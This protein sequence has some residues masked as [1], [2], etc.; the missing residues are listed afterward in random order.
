V[1]PKEPSCSVRFGDVTKIPENF[2][3]ASLTS[4]GFVQRSNL[5]ICLG[6]SRTFEFEPHQAMT[7]EA[8]LAAN[9]IRKWVHQVIVTALFSNR[10]TLMMMKLCARR[11]HGRSS[12]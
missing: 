2:S 4:K 9:H 10:R 5:A 1:V 11:D 7:K 3:D 6:D 8:G 12:Q